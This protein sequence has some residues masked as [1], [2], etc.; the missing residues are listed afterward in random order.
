MTV[1]EATKRPQSWWRR[2]VSALI[3]AY[4]LITI[5]ETVAM[6]ILAL[7]SGSMDLLSGGS[8]GVTL[9]GTFSYRYHNAAKGRTVDI[10]VTVPTNDADFGRIIVDTSDFALF[11]LSG[12]FGPF[13]DAGR[14]SVALPPEVHLDHE[15][16]ATVILQPLRAGSR[17]TL[18]VGSPVGW[19]GRLLVSLPSALIWTG[20]GTASV[21]FATFL[22][23][24]VNGQPF[25]PENPRRM[26]W[27]GGSLAMVVFADSWLRVWIVRAMLDVLNA[28]GH[29]IPLQANNPGIN[30]GPIYVI[31]GVLCLAAAFRAGTRMAADT[32][33]LV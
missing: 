30:P 12:A 7:V 23:S 32:D 10:P 11:G 24:I 1:G 17:L 25:D 14:G 3:T 9:T 31:I 18:D 33:G 19:R 15:R 4:V 8:P 27:L 26:L 13:G 29:H 21:T 16:N 2:V 5:L 20:L 22:R 6:V 28:H